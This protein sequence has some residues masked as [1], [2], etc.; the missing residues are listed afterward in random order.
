MSLLRRADFLF[1][2]ATGLARA[3]VGPAPSWQ[4]RASR[5][6]DPKDAPMSHRAIPPLSAV[7]ASTKTKNDLIDK[8]CSGDVMRLHARA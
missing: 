2:R 5:F 3:S 1:R 4:R 6:R 8:H 7:T